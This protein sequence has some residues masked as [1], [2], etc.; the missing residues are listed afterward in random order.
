MA[1]FDEH[2]IDG[3]E[4]VAW[5]GKAEALCQQGKCFTVEHFNIEFHKEDADALVREFGYDYRF[6]DRRLDPTT[7]SYAVFGP[8]QIVEQDESI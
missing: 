6:R 2:I 4:R 7:V 5:V 3:R 8:R 1:T